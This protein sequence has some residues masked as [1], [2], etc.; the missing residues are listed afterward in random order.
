MGFVKVIKN[1]AYYMRYQVKFRRRREGKTDYQQRKALVFQDKNKYNARK[2]RLVARISNKYVTCQIVYSTITGDHVMESAHSKELADFGAKAGYSNYAACYAT[3]LLCA[4]RLL[5]KLKLD[6]H[7][8]GNE[9][10]DGEYFEVEEA[11]DG[12][13]PFVA[14]LD[15]GL[16]RTSTGAR[17]FG[18]LKGAADGGIAIPHGENRFPGYDGD[19]KELDAETHKKYIFGGHVSEYMEYLEDE[20]QSQYNALF[21]QYIKAGVGA[22]DVEGM[23]EETHAAIRADP[24]RKSKGDKKYNTVVKGRKAALS[25]QQRQD[26]ARQKIASFEWKLS[27]EEAE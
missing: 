16:A 3:G 14:Y 24:S 19:E 25:R 6:S 12:P 2:Y 15:V 17:V 18:C 27:K 22:D 4:R 26:K 7:Y 5:K 13:R 23:W 11:E 10:V 21:S 9:E 8:A 20:D 1:K